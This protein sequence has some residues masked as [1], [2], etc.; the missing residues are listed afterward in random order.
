MRSSNY[1]AAVDL[2]TSNVTVAVG[3]PCEGDK[4]KVLAVATHKSKEMTRGEVRNVEQAAR[5]IREAVSDIEQ[6]LN[7]KI[8]EVVT[9]ISGAHLNCT[10]H[11]YY[12][13]ISSKDGEVFQEDVDNLNR[14]MSSVQAPD[15]HQILRILPQHYVVTDLNEEITK[16]PVGMIGQTLGSTFNLITGESSIISRLEKTME[17]A[18]LKNRQLYINPLAAAEA[19]TLPDERDMGVAVVDLGG[20]TTDVCIYEDGIVRYIGVIPLGAYAINKDIRSYGIIERYIE[21]LKVTYGVALESMVDDE[22]AVEVPGHV[23]NEKKEITFINLAKIVEARMTEIAEYVKEEIKVSGYEGRL[24]A[25]IILT[26]GSAKLIEIKTLFEQV[27]KLDVRLATPTVWVSEESREMVNNCHFST[28]VG[29]LREAM[30]D[31]ITTDVELLKVEEPEPVVE[32]VVNVPTKRVEE[33]EE[34]DDYDDYD[35][36]SEGRRRKKGGLFGR[37]KNAFE[38]T[39]DLKVLDDDSDRI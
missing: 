31:G 3:T 9:G 15:G 17:R 38:N 27:V 32:P 33:E 22:R 37:I 7:I 39:F 6:K 23:P 10:K 34:Y 28:V 4:I 25:G 13:Y 24:R 2:G 5:S 29:L 8:N 18:S 1:I 16:N 14:S 35:E 30:L 21:E 19:V 20:G 12:V 26:G 11:P 36:P